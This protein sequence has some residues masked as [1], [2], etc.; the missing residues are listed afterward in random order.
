M[1]RGSGVNQAAARFS[2][3]MMRPSDT[4][5]PIIGSLSV[6]RKTARSS[7]APNS[8]M[9]M[10]ASPSPTQKPSPAAVAKKAT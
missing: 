7:N 8:A 6:R 10:M 5:S 4:V 1:K 9:A 2:M 3:I